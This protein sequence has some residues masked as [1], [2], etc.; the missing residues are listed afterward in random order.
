MKKRKVRVFLIDG[1]R[2]FVEAFIFLCKRDK[3]MSVVGFS[4]TGEGILPELRRK[5]P[6]MVIIDVAVV[7]IDGLALVRS[8]SSEFKST[9]VMVLSLY[10]TPELVEQ[11]LQSGACAFLVKGISGQKILETICQIMS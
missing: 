10:D 9:K 4:L 3:K 11:A 5:K 2:L 7:G 6:N 1:S 8:I